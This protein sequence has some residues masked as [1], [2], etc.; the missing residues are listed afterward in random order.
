MDSMRDW[1]ALIGRALLAIVF[2][3]A[4]YSKIG[5]FAATAGYMSSKGLPAVDVLL[6]A[7]IVLELAGGI[8]LLVGWKARWVAL[9]LAVF[10]LL[11]ALLFHNYWAM[12]EAQ[13][14]MQRL[15]FTKNLGLAGGLLV[16]AGL[17]AGRLSIDRR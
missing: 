7:T 3:P 2:I 6:V 8:A 13:Q 4:G 10:T 16:V 15:M 12:P 14:M 17:G 11:A 9:A 5:G 1:A